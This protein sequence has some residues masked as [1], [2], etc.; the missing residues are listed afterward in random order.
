MSRLAPSTSRRLVAIAT[1]GALLAS[2]AACGSDEDPSSASSVSG[3]G[4]T[5]LA[6][7]RL[8]TAYAGFYGEPQADTPQPEA[9]KNS[10]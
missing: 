8:E 4:A 7:N 3:S 2:A 9:V 10:G 1:A 5:Q 6:E